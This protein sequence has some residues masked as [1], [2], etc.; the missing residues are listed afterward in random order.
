MNNEVLI[1][2]LFILLM[3]FGLI[4]TS[5]YLIKYFK[6][7][8]K[9]KK[10]F[11]ILLPF[12]VTYIVITQFI[13]APKQVAGNSMQPTLKNGDGILIKKY[14]KN[15]Q[16]GD[17]IIFRSPKYPDIEYISRLI[18]LPKDK[19]KIKE[20][21]VYLNGKLLQEPYTKTLTNL[22]EGGCIKE[23]EEYLFSNNEVFVMSDNR[24]K[25]SDS[26]EYCAIPLANIIGK[27]VYK[28]W[29]GK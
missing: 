16:R 13:I 20:G 6:K 5:F 14:D 2:L 26:R 17:I 1:F 21:K 27:Y 23:G 22:W 29:E 7:I 18:A 12:I 25:A 10:I 3:F 8:N 9:I 4:I 15:Y 19:I 11:L 28:Y 24:P